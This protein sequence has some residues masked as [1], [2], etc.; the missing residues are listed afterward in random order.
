[1]QRGE[2]KGS[3]MY[4]RAHTHTYIH[5]LDSHTHTH[6]L[7]PPCSHPTLSHS[8]LPFTFTRAAAPEREELQIIPPSEQKEHPRFIPVSQT[9]KTP[10]QFASSTFV[11]LPGGGEFCR[12]LPDTTRSHSWAAKG[13]PPSNHTTHHTVRSQLLNGGVDSAGT[14]HRK[15][16]RVE[17]QF[18]PR[19]QTV[20]YP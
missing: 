15:T 1:V 19:A 20:W 16:S 11:V 3:E 2:V 7:S 9:Q 4:T 5:L 8:P 13:T 18:P 12:R 17:R 14:T 10:H 6:T